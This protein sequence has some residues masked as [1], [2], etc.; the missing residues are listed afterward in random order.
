M[1]VGGGVEHHVRSVLV[2]HGV[3]LATVADVG[4]HLDD[5][6]VAKFAGDVVEVGLVVVEQD[7][8][9]GI[10]GEHLAGDLGADRTA[11]AGDQHPPTGQDRP[12][13]VEIGG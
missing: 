4:Q 3:H 6:V 1:L 5:D 10:A 8:P 11:G 9:L 7:Q 13:R 2:E 12:D